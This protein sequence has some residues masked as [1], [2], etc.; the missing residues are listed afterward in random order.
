M[1]IGEKINTIE[2]LVI[3]SSRVSRYLGYPR[4]VPLWEVHFSLPVKCNLHRDESNSDI[5]LEIEK[6]KGK[7]FVPALSS[8]ES[9]LRLRTLLPRLI[10][11]FKTIR[12]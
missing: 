1:T 8:K 5:S 11:I 3:D 9:I 10:T 2:R 4:K 7:A 6:C 12:A